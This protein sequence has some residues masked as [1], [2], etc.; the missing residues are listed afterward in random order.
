MAQGARAAGGEATQAAPQLLA[1]NAA[2]AFAVCTSVCRQLVY[3]W[4]RGG[5]LQMTYKRSSTNNGKSIPRPFARSAAA[6]S[7]PPVPT[8]SDKK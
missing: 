6:K 7:P 2:R 4:I 8:L 1:S 3:L 5:C